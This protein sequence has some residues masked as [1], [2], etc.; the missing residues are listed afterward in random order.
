[1]S[2]NTWCSKHVFVSFLCNK[3]GSIRWRLGRS[4]ITYYR[5]KKKPEYF[6][7]TFDQRRFPRTFSSF[8]LATCKR[9][10]IAGFLG[11][12][13]R[14]RVGRTCAAAASSF[15]RSKRKC[16]TTTGCLENNNWRPRGRNMMFGSKKKGECVPRNHAIFSD[17]SFVTWLRIQQ[18]RWFLVYENKR[19]PIINLFFFHIK[20]KKSFYYNFIA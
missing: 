14:C 12:A 1:M 11:C 20:K 3:S 7:T 10:F 5:C 4:K 18:R 9:V 16:G 15:H 13:A 19:L 17:K 2:T 8:T 6:A